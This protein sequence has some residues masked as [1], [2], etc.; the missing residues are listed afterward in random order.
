MVNIDYFI[1]IK[2]Y[3]PVFYMGD[4]SFIYRKN[5]ER[6]I[7]CKNMPILKVLVLPVDNKL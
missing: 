1:L 2:G 4:L 7:T 5:I 3:F 6:K